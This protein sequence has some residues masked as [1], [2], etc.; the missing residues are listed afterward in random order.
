MKEVVEAAHVGVPKGGAMQEA[1]GTT[2]Q[3][4]KLALIVTGVRGWGSGGADWAGAWKGGAEGR[5]RGRGALAGAVVLD[6]QVFDTVH[7]RMEGQVPA[8]GAGGA[9]GTESVGA[10][11]STEAAGARATPAPCSCSSSSSKCSR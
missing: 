6:H 1:R 2:V 5:G 8:A 11:G 4:G 3:P 9:P 10:E 7:R